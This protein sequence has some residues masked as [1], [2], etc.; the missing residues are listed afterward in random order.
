MKL[1]PG[2]FDTLATRITLGFW[3]LSFLLATGQCYL[4]MYYWDK[5]LAALEQRVNDELAYTLESELAP[6]LNKGFSHR[7]LQIALNRLAE[8]NPRIDI[9]LLDS[10]G[11]VQ[12]RSNAKID[13]PELAPQFDIQ[14]IEEFLRFR[15]N[16]PPSLIPNPYYFDR[17]TAFSATRISTSEQSGYLLALLHGELFRVAERGVKNKYL[18]L[19]GIITSAGLFL[20]LAIF[21]TFL[22]R[23]ITRRFSRMVSDVSDIANGQFDVEIDARGS[24]EVARLGSAINTMSRT[25]LG[26]LKTTQQAD[27]E[28]RELMAMVAHDLGGPLAAIQGTTELLLSEP[29]VDSKPSLQTRLQAVRNNTQRLTAMTKELSELSKLENPAT[30]HSNDVFSIV[31]LL[32]DDII[33]RLE[34]LAKEQRVRIKLTADE[35]LP[36]VEADVELI[37]RV[38]K[39]LLENAIRYNSAGGEVEV[40]VTPVNSSI[41]SESALKI[42]VRNDG[43]GIAAEDLPNIFNRFYRGSQ[44]GRTKIAGTGLGLAIVKRA[45]E[46]H[47]SD[48][49]VSSIPNTKTEFRF[50]LP[51]VRGESL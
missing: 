13:N 50:E 47:G 44:E 33:P 3:V 24:D 35:N 8:I 34:P 46:L 28:R 39:N 31:E 21:G 41:H 18:L 48:I 5:G 23:K 25:I 45:L 10:Q 1:F 12:A 38:L 16:R 14:Q 26:S 9:F 37:D 2:L 19:G 51:S 40:S 27:K 22:F 30:P 4:L 29:E 6:L 43:P 7:K 49:E 20:L 11:R 42:C 17:P 32:S 15:V 36:P